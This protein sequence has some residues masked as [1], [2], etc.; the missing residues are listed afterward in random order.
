MGFIINP[1]S[2]DLGDTPIENIFLDVY[3]PMANGTFVKVYLLAYKY[4]LDTKSLGP[5]EDNKF[6]NATLAKHLKI[7]LADVLSAWDFWEDK[8]I[9]KKHFTSE[10]EDE[11]N[12]S[13]EFVSLKQL[14]IDNTYKRIQAKDNRSKAE[15]EESFSL[16]TK[17]LVEANQ[18]PMIKEMFVEI[19]AV[20]NRP[21]VPN[22]KRT[23]L[24][25]F[26]QFNIEPPLIIKAFSFCK[27]KKKIKNVNYVGGVIRNWYDQNITTVEQLQEYLLKQGERYGVYDRVYKAL[28]FGYRS[29][30][31]AD[32]KI[33]DQW[34]DEYKFTL[35]IIL[36]ACEN[37]SKTSNPNINYIHSILT[38][39]YNKG[40]KTLDDIQLLDVKKDTPSPKKPFASTKE[41]RFKTRFHLSESRGDKYSNDE[42]EKMLLEKQK[43]N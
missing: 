11:T 43:R 40:I 26:H 42:I 23:V 14:Y 33:M 7:P 39:W 20:M 30:A 10:D 13:V 38:D 37:S 8:Q 6:N 32:M 27:H 31:E 3:M 36:K 1:P 25:W 4:A 18:V 22:E 28:G 5:E 16:T 29:P 17:D 15:A 2:I 34:I 19:N 41:P 9:I 24:E 21:L 12:Y 35:E